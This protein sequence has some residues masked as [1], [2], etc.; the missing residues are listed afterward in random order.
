LSATP[1][2]NDRLEDVFYWH[3][4]S[5][6]YMSKKG[7]R[8]IEVIVKY[9]KYYSDL[10]KEKRRWNGAYDLHKMLEQIIENEARNEFIARQIKYL[11]NRDRKLLVLSGR[12]SH[13]KF[14]KEKVDKLKF[15]KDTEN[16]KLL[17]DYFPKNVCKIIS[18]YNRDFI[19]TGYYIG[20][21]KPSELE[22][23]SRADVI[24]GTYQLISEG[25]DIPTLD[26]LIM[27][28]PKKSIEQV[29]GRILRGKSKKTPLVIDMCDQ[30]SVY[31]NQGEFRARHYRVCNYHQDV[32][33]VYEDDGEVPILQDYMETEGVKRKKKSS[34]SA[35]VE[36]S[37]GNLMI[38]FD[39]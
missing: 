1:K 35:H 29:V 10:Y 3:L 24:F 6:G 18:K 27:M 2:R 4:G 34:R 20:G 14:M 12:K 21:M 37:F 5:I 39:D 38:D 36:E 28:S 15:S 25:M 30:F 17:S 9:V 33:E 19:T 23:S 16:N 7:D 8:N 26:T 13:L 31:I 32:S 22:V 11:S